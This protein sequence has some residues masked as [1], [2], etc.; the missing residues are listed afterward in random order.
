MAE[1]AR[2]SFERMSEQS[3][4]RIPGDVV[5]ILR[6]EAHATFV[7]DGADLLMTLQLP[8]KQALGG[9]RHEIRHLD[10]HVVVIQNDGVSHPGQVLTLPGE[11]LPL[12]NVPSE[13]GALRV[14]LRIAFPKVLTAAERAFVAANFQDDSGGVG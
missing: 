7:R 9:F 10:D 6:T 2:V 12:H 13:F 5:V 11:G 3:P 4:G 1:D 8:L 14:T